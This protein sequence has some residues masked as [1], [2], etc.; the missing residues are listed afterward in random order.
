M[1]RPIK[2]Q[3]G[4]NHS[5]LSR[6]KAEMIICWAEPAMEVMDSVMIKAINN[7]ISEIKSRR[8]LSQIFS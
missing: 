7:P 6:Y 3:A 5:M 1:A 2:C 4:F 8:Y